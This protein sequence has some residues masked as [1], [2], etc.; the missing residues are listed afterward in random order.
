VQKEKKKKEEKEKKKEKKK[1][2][3][4]V[5][6]VAEKVSRSLPR[7]MDFG[8]GYLE[9]RLARMLHLSPFRTV[10]SRPVPG[11][12]QRFIQPRPPHRIPL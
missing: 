2:G 1:D 12:L 4:G 6:R 3:T 10:P 9:D 11:P 7:A 8:R 5:R